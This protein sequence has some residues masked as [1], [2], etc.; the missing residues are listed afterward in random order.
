V[1]VH[2]RHT[3]WET[4]GVLNAKTKNVLFKEATTAVL[5]HMEAG[6]SLFDQTN[7]LFCGAAQ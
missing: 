2:N 4:P 3:L 7:E 6:H 5:L 1:S